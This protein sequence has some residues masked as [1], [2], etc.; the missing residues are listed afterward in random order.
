VDTD[1]LNDRKQADGS[2]IHDLHCTPKGY[3]TLGQRFA[4][5]A[6]ALILRHKKG[7]PCDSMVEML[8]VR[9]PILENLGQTTDAKAAKKLATTKPTAYPKSIYEEFHEKLKELRLKF[10]N[11]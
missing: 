9:S 3:K 7:H 11:P 1:D 6:I 8:T 4:N 5:K 2:I 10:G